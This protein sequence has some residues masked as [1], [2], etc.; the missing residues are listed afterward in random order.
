MLELPVGFALHPTGIDIKMLE[1]IKLLSSHSYWNSKF[2]D[3]FF[4]ILSSIIAYA[5]VPIVEPVQN[6][7]Q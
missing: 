7:L 2:S 5:D 3:L 4:L 6:L 1:G